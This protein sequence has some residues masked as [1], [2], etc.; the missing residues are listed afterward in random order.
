MFWPLYFTSGSTGNL[1][2]SKRLSTSSTNI[3]GRKT[4]TSSANN[5]RSLVINS[6]STT[7]TVA[8]G[9]SV[10]SRPTT[11]TFSPSTSSS[12]PGSV[13][14][15]RHLGRETPTRHLGRETPTRHLGRETPTRTLGRETPSKSLSGSTQNL[16]PTRQRR[17]PS[18]P[19]TSSSSSSGFR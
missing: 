13:T 7:P 3:S 8:F 19:R 2:R 12:R 16:A 11:P 5:R 1:N 17:L 14:P 15:T 10:R 9:S 6:R 18:T 4:P